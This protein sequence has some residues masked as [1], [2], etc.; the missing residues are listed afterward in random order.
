MTAAH[1]AH[2]ANPFLRE[3][4][5]DRTAARQS[6]AQVNLKGKEGRQYLSII[7]LGAT[8]RINLNQ[9]SSKGEKRWIMCRLD[10]IHRAKPP[11]D[12]FFFL[13]GPVYKAHI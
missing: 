8:R 12:N 9:G 5:N 6:P 1:P 2:Q 10:H 13:A 11:E 4:G 7:S 3:G